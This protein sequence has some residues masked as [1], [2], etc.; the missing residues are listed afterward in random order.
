VKN[1]AL[2]GL[3]GYEADEDEGYGGMDE[4]A[5]NTLPPAAGFIGPQREPPSYQQTTRISPY[6]QWSFSRLEGLRKPGDEGDAGDA[7]SMAAV[8][9][10][11]DEDM[12][13]MED[14]GRDSAHQN[15]PV[16]Q[17]TEVEYPGDH[18]D[19]DSGKR[20]EDADD[21]EPVDIHVD[22]PPHPE[23]HQKNE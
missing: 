15:S 12:R 3:D 1:G 11:D 20:I 4:D 6:Q 17:S 19:L 7:D 16:I 22:S 23:P 5:D 21:P 10:V 13:L 18:M 9:D 2:L 8:D 14:F